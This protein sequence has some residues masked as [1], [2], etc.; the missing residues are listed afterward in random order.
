MR[1]ED[2]RQIDQDA[3]KKGWCLLYTRNEVYFEAYDVV[4]DVKGKIGQEDILELHLFD[5]K[6]EYRALSSSS[7]RFSSGVIET[8]VIEAEESCEDVFVTRV[9]LEKKYG[10]DIQVINRLTYDD[11]GSLSISNY[12]LSKGGLV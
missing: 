4:D 10:K 5:E 12:R 8:C 1:L 2:L 9:A 3:P 6:R 11:N 7:R